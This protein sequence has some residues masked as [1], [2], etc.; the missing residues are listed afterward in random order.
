MATFKIP[1]GKTYEFG[2]TVLE[3]DS[4]LPKDLANMDLVNSSFVLT[5][6]DTLTN[7]AGAITMVRVPDPKTPGHESDPDTYVNGKLL[8]TIPSA[9]TATLEYERGSKIDDYYL[10][11]TYQGLITVAFT[12]D[13][14]IVSVVN[15]IA[16]VPL[17]A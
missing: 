7:V 6:L 4:Y 13:T 14:D 9:V 8:V 10:K 1:K 2:I 3:K 16:V 11:P 12:D 15:D 5:K 17:G